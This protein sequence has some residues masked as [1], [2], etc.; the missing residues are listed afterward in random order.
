MRIPLAR[1]SVVLC[2]AAQGFTPPKS[3]SGAN[4]AITRR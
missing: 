1:L 3:P 4:S 2:S